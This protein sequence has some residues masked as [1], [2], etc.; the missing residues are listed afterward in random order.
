M[1]RYAKE[2]LQ[3]TRKIVVKFIELQRVS[4]A[5]CGETFPGVHRAVPQTVSP[6]PGPESDER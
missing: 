6:V 2:A 4:P 5:N 3:A 1:D